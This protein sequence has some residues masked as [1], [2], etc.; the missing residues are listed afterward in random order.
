MGSH[1]TPDFV[2]LILHKLFS[3]RPRDIEDIQ[4]VVQVSGEVLDW[5]YIEQ[6][7]REFT[8]IPGRQPWLN[9]NLMNSS[10]P[11]PHMPSTPTIGRHSNLETV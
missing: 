8:A 11:V 3:G 6:W 5:A 4:G 7:A 1:Q 10:P 2:D 9:V